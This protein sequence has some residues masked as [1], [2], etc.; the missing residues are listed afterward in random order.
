ML[1]HLPQQQSKVTRGCKWILLAGAVGIVVFCMLLITRYANGRR[2]STAGKPKLVLLM[3]PVGRSGSTWLGKMLS[4]LH[5]EGL[6]LYE[7]EY[8]LTRSGSPVIR[9]D[10][11]V[12]LIAGLFNCKITEEF[13]EWMKSMPDIRTVYRHTFTTRVCRRLDWGCLQADQLARLCGET[14]YRLIKTIRLRLSWIRRLLAAPD[15][16]LKVAFLLRDPRASLASRKRLGWSMGARE[17]CPRIEEDLGHV[18][19]LE[20]LF[21][22]RFFFL[23]YEDACW[24]PYGS[25]LS[26]YRFLIGEGVAALPEVWR[27]YLD[28]TASRTEAEE[29]RKEVD[30]ATLEEVEE[31]CGR[32]IDFLGYSHFAST[33]EMRNL[34]IPLLI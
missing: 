1:F 17:L 20:R 11:A 4:L 27:S 12:S 26:I 16:N 18:A 10:E 5:P 23:K 29:W 7:P 2:G 31:S 15:L 25:A 3:A 24:E 19:E 34:T 33:R 9:E 22:D 6:Y 30:G 13:V 21:P 28:Q 32:V 14:K 8:M